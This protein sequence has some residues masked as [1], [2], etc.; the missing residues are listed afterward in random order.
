MYEEYHFIITSGKPFIGQQGKKI[1]R[2][3]KEGGF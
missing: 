2:S 1:S 3:R